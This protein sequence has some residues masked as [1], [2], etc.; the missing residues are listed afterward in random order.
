MIALL[1]AG[2]FF[3]LER[4]MPAVMSCVFGNDTPQDA[5]RLAEAS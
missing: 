4:Y 1:M 5:I 2:A 3:R